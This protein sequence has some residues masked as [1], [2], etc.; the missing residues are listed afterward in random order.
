MGR[1][2]IL[3]VLIVKRFS[4]IF[5]TLDSVLGIV[6]SLFFFRVGSTGLS[7]ASSG[8]VP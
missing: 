1:G 7:V 5:V 3:T 6:G 8:V 2:K 4:Y